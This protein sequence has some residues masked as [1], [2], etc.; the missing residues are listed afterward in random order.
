MAINPSMAA[1]ML[2][3]ANRDV[4]TAAE[5]RRG[6]SHPSGLA[7]RLTAGES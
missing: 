6:I 2:V 7:S 5:A 4:R 1:A 3:F